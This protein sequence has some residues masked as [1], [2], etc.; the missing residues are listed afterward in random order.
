MPVWLL[1]VLATGFCAAAI[2]LRRSSKALGTAALLAGLA[3]LA[4][5]IVSWYFVWAASSR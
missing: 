5:A 4:V 2:A 3:C 1:L